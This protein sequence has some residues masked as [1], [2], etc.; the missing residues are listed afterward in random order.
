[1]CMNENSKKKDVL[2]A[3]CLAYT[4]FGKKTKQ[5][6]QEL[7]YKNYQN[8]WNAAVTNQTCV[9]TFCNKI[10]HSPTLTPKTTHIHPRMAL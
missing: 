6:R 7:F 8:G 10:N 1:M 2:V 9:K 5:S 4:E 3:S